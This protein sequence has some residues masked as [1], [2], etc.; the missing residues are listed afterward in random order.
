M[1]EKKI[2]KD[3]ITEMIEREAI[4]KTLRADTIEEFAKKHNIVMS[5]YSYQKNKK[6]NQ[7]KII[8]L[9]L[10]T[11]K[12]RT[13]EVLE[14]L[15]KNAE[16]GKEKS[17]EMFLKFIIELSEKTDITSGGEVIKGFNFIKNDTD[18]K[19][20]NSSIAETRES[21]GDITEPQE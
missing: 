4:P 20:H 2:N 14:K 16:E 12:E 8:K 5:N 21:V 10:N 17:I 3:W 9:C 11:A 19:S 6:E 1:N 15:G 13:P 18:E 7:Q